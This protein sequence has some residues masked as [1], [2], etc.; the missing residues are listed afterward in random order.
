MALKN[1]KS[2]DMEILSIYNFQEVLRQNCSKHPIK[3][4]F[5]P[6]AEKE[7]AK[8]ILSQIK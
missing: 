8:N 2:Q 5:F 6:V 4:I 7:Y 3:V 1:F